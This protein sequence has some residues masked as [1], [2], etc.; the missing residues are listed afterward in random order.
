MRRAPRLPDSR[1]SAWMHLRIF[2]SL[3]QP[4]APA[5]R[6]GLSLT[7]G[8]R[9]PAGRHLTVSPVHEI[10][11]TPEHGTLSQALT[12]D[13]TVPPCQELLALPREIFGQSGR[14]STVVPLTSPSCLL[15]SRGGS[16]T[17]AR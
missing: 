2:G 12:Q 5:L 17:L 1:A 3:L 15:T 9:A 8:L 16:E 14:R 11:A 7:A 10:G 6:A 13:H 4:A